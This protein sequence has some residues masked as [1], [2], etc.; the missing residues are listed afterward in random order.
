MNS[1]N[2][3]YLISPKFTEI[4]T[5]QFEN[6]FLVLY[7]FFL[8]LGY[9][10]VATWP[11]WQVHAGLT[12]PSHQDFQMQYFCVEPILFVAP[13]IEIELIEWAGRKIAQTQLFYQL[14]LRLSSKSNS[15]ALYVGPE[16]ICNI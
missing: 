15:L 8:V 6:W 3:I 12:Q 13:S 7:A 16:P 1:C 14:A 10:W 11:V 5:G 4:Q 9:R 2:Q